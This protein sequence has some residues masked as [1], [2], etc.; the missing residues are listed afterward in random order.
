MFKK[1]TLQGWRQFR[2]VEINFHPRLTVLTGANGAGKTTLLNLVSRHFG[3]GATFISTPTRRGSNAGLMYSSDFWDLEN[4]EINSFDSLEREEKHRNVA[5]AQGPQTVIGEI[6]YQNGAGAA[7]SVPTSQ[8]GSSYD[9]NISQQ[10]GVEGLHIP[11][12]RATSNYQQVQNIPTIP[13]RRNEVFR[14][15]LNLIKTRYSGGHTQWSPQYYMKETLI[16][17]AT[18]G[19]GNAA[20]EADPESATV[21]EGFQEILRKMLPPKL[22]FKRLHVRV[23]EVILETE[24]G[25]FSIDALSGGTAAVIDLAWQVFMYEPSG[26]EFVVTLDEPE[27]HLHPE[28]QQRVLANLLTAFPSVQ[29]V[30]A[31]H[32][33]FIVGSVP[34]SHVYVLGYDEIRR[35][36]STLL[37]TV[38]KT[39]TANEILRDVLGLE[40]T[41]P[42]WVENRLE[43]LVEEY[44]NRD[45]TKDTLTTL[46]EEMTSLGL[47]KHIPQ[48]ISM[49]AEKKDG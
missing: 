7:I 9:V 45:F 43:N 19:Y 39:G 25:N 17:L 49:L 44:S 33:P 46:R 41:I 23:P 6:I 28:L 35:V 36:N 30:V 3:W 31:T 15:Y 5:A 11:S 1:I 22:G 2:N 21:F 32:S 26:K 40:F 27:N 47:G 37:D 34:N 13:R 20:V 42:V 4:A 18:F 24:T 48:T 10:Q 16:G 8:I 12:H 38:N 29:F 14:H